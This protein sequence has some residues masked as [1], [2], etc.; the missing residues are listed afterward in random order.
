MIPEINFRAVLAAT[1]SSLVIGSIWYI[2]NLLG[3]TWGAGEGHSLSSDARSAVG[4][5]LATFVVSI[6]T[7]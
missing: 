6:V 5:N 7:P 2:P 3:S 4:P 1:A